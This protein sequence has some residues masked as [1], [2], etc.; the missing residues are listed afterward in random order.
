MAEQK[1]LHAVVHG[2]VQG[3]SFRYYTQQTAQKLNIVG[4]VRNN[5]DG[6]VEVTAEGSVEQLQQLLDFLHQ[7]SPAAQ[8]EAVDV[9]WYNAR[10]EFNDFRVT[11]RTDLA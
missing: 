2:R 9:I 10:G 6:T 7:G 11:Y 4:W 3:V 5:S 1:R 8:V